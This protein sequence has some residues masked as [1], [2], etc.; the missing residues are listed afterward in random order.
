MIAS[1]STCS[2][3]TKE[4]KAVELV[5][6]RQDRVGTRGGRLVDSALLNLLGEIGTVT[7]LCIIDP[8]NARQTPMRSLMNTN[9]IQ[10]LGIDNPGGVSTGTMHDAFNE[11]MPVARMRIKFVLPITSS[12]VSP[13]PGLVPE[14]TDS[15]AKRVRDR[16]GR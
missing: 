9:S 1:L 8:T 7:A 3:A 12:P 2:T 16:N 10:R 13:T 15:L 11:V 5:N 6:A 14:W 4:R